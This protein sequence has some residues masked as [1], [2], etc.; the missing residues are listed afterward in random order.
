[1]I[2]PADEV[3]GSAVEAGAPE[4]IDVLCSGSERLADIFCGG[5]LWLD[6][7]MVDEYGERFFDS[8]AA[9]QDAEL[10]KLVEAETALRQR[11]PAYGSANENMGHR[12]YST[13]P[14]HSLAPGARFFDWVRKMT[15]DAFYTSP[16]GVKD[17]GY[18]GN[19]GMTKYEVPEEAIAYLKRKG[20]LS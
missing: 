4:F 9:K 12:E 18:M 20:A 5:I 11:K 7:H 14:T 16:I 13:E 8:T 1:M 3:S 15:V 19:T 6:N 10:A 17:V 2:I